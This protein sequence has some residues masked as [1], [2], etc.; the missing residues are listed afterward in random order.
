LTLLF[1]KKVI[2]STA[3]G[4]EPLSTAGQK[5][6]ILA[7]HPPEKIFPSALTGPANWLVA[8]VDPLPRWMTLLGTS[9]ALWHCFSVTRLTIDP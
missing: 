6:T 4:C 7:I 9:F 5:D 8:A 1:F 2:A 3:D